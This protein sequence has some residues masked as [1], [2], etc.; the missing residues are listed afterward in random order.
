MAAKSILAHLNHIMSYGV[1]CRSHT[2]TYTGVLL[3]YAKL[4]SDLFDVCQRF[5]KK[6]LRRAYAG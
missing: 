5:N 4:T 1:R 6:Y 2:V 3:T